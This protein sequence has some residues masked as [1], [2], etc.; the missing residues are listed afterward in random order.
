MA[1]PTRRGTRLTWQKVLACIL[2]LPCILFALLLR[3]LIFRVWAAAV[4][5]APSPVFGCGYL[6]AVSQQL[7]LLPVPAQACNASDSPRWLHAR[8]VV[9]H[10]APKIC[11]STPPYIVIERASPHRRPAGAQTRLPGLRRRS[12][13]PTPLRRPHGDRRPRRGQPPPPP[14]LPR[15]RSASSWAP[16]GQVMPPAPCEHSSPS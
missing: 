16:G 4:A 1:I 5:A 7:P 15:T 2:M 10:V 14:P 12:S 11:R 9:L 6:I 8:S 13:K 3:H